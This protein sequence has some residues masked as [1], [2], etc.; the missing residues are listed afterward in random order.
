M[1]AAETAEEKAALRDQLLNYCE[2]D[3]YAMVEIHRG[4]RELVE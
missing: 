4:L 2:R 3:T 1:V